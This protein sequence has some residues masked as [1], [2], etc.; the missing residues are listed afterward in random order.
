MKNLKKLT[1]ILLTMLSAMTI[2]AGCSFGGTSSPTDSST[3]STQSTES[4]GEENQSTDSTDGSDE[5][6]NSGDEGG[7]GGDEDDTH[8]KTN[9]TF[10]EWKTVTPVSCTQDGLFQRTCLE[11]ETHVES[12]T[13]DKRTH[14]YGYN[15]LC[16]CKAVPTLPSAPASGYIEA[17]DP[18][19]GIMLSDSPTYACEMYNRYMLSVDTYYTAELNDLGEF[20][21]QF[22]VPEAGQYAVV[23]YNTPANTTLE[24]YDGN[25]QYVNPQIMQG[26]TLENGNLITTVNCGEQYY[27]PEWISV[28]CIRG[29][30]AAIV[31]FTIVKVGEPAW[32]P[33]NVYQNVE[34]QQINDVKAPEGA[35]GTKATEVPYETTGIYL[36]KTTGWYCMP[37]GEVIYAAISMK[38]ERQFGGGTIAFTDLLNEGSASNFRIYKGKLPTGDYLIYDYTS[39]FMADPEL[40]GENYNQNSYQAQANSD[41]LYPVTQELYEFLK[42]HAANNNPAIPPEA[43]NAENAWLSVCYYYEVLQEGSEGNPYVQTEVGTFTATRYSKFAPV[44]YTFLHTPADGTTTNVTY[45]ITIN[46][47]GVTLLL[48][49]VQYQNKDGVLGIQ[50]VLFESN[51]TKG[52][53][54]QLSTVDMNL[55]SIEVTVQ[56]ADGSAQAP[57]TATLGEQSLSCSPVLCEDGTTK[58]ESFYVYTATESGTL[59]LTSNEEMNLIMRTSEENTATF[60]EG[61]AILTVAAGETVLIY[62]STANG[63]NATVNLAFAV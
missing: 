30:A 5:D 9:C 51:G 57:Y 19:S 38:A 16:A 43:E 35:K 33:S 60:D 13:I 44:Y 17:T 39:M 63:A 58:Y 54:F 53:T 37:S 3:E 52:T 22:G 24:R 1:M 29:E 47:D 32:M 23:V 11:N 62:F 7:N 31:Q 28:G 25:S 6:G 21:F 55:M 59:T 10:S 8:D 15:G 45:S 26:R 50:N 27:N 20:W 2:A 61:S 14:D 4:T 18:S 42:V 56:Y 40:T 36:D 12:L 49:G 34:A 48:N 46:T 41:G